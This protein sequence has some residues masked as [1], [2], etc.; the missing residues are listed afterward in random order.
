MS[1]SPVLRSSR[2]AGR[3]AA[4]AWS[5]GL[6]AA[7]VVALV[8]PAR[9]ALQGGA[10]TPD[11]VPGTGALP[12]LNGDAHALATFDDG[13]GPALIIGGAFTNAAGVAASRVVRWDGQSYTP[14][15][16]GL[17][18]DLH[19]L[20]VFDD[21]AGPALFAGG[22]FTLAGDQPAANVARWD[23]QAWSALGAGTGGTVLTLGAYDDGSGPALYAGGMFGLAGGAPAQ[24][25]AR[26][27]GQAWSAL[28]A[29]TD[30]QVNA[31]CVYDDGSGPALFAG[32]AF[33]SAGGAPAAKIAV[34]D[35][36]T[37]SA[38]G[39][40]VG[41]TIPFFENPRV[42]ALRVFDDGTGPGLYAGGSFSLAGGL[43]AS[44]V[45][46]WDAQGWSAVGVGV[47][48]SMLDFVRELHT[49]DDG[50]GG[51]PRLFVGGRFTS[52]FGARALASWDGQ[53]WAVVNDNPATMDIQALAAFD[54]GSGEMLFAGGAF[55]EI[56]GVVT[57]SI[58]AWGGLAWSELGVPHA[59]GL[60]GG[61]L[62]L[63][64]HDGGGVAGP[65]LVAA[66]TFHLAG[67]QTVEGI[68]RWDGASWSALGDGPGGLASVLGVYDDGRGAGPSL[69]AGGTFYSP[70]LMKTIRIAR[71]D[72]TTWSALGSDINGYANVMRAFDDGSGPALFVGGN[73]TSAGGI[74]ARSIAR[75]DGVS[76]TNLAAGFDFGVHALCVFDDGTGPALYAGGSFTKSGSLTVN[77][78]AKWDGIRWSALGDG[79]NEG[80]M[81]LCVYDDGSGPAL[82]AGGGFT[83]SGALPLNGIARWD[84]STWSDVGGGVDGWVHSLAVAGGDFGGGPRL[85]AGGTFSVAGG[86]PAASVAQ[87]DGSAWSPLGA[88]LS[89]P[90]VALAA[91]DDGS[92]SGEALFAGGSFATSPAHDSFLAKWACPGSAIEVVPGCFGN[93]AVLAAQSGDVALGQTFLA[94][95]SPSSFSTGAG[96]LLL[97]L[98]NTDAAGCGVFVPGIG[99]LLLSAS[100]LV[101]LASG[102]LSGGSLGFAL[103]V[104]NQPSLLGAAVALHGACIGLGSPG[105]PIELSNGLT[106]TIVQ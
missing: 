60:D 81:A 96:A 84:G 9:A 80:A 2:L 91:F 100:P 1:S 104:P 61:V 35:G 12:G 90:A 89:S 76:W 54:V 106:A 85:F 30:G 64:V 40:G 5:L 33:T 48:T 17:N 59:F 66:G 28:G 13:S 70:E 39:K 101:T 75:W 27:D 6:T 37:W 94:T 93:P 14:L 83:A 82:Y 72:G 10:C 50:L 22:E 44:K 56:G 99:E 41:S 43:P 88:G 62:D 23:G 77:G 71:W 98:D 86:Q 69:Y 15:G 18:G 78:I 58:A 29:G 45:A 67:T 95:L 79:L 20:L 103:P 52:T 24:N 42:N 51:G 73:F 7:A 26:W 4:P 11:W 38:L 49:H 53:S 19:A 63:V 87:W 92:G 55:D 31:L 16:Q 36:Q 34:W 32:G 68:A 46:R 65:T 57:Q 97:G 3:A 8:L 25:V 21:G 74:D 105:V 102:P 47:G